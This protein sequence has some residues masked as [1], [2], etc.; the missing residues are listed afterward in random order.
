MLILKIVLHTIQELILLGLEITK[1]NP[2]AITVTFHTV[3]KILYI[4]QRITLRINFFF[5]LSSKDLIFRNNST[6][7]NMRRFA[8]FTFLP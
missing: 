6:L 5:F 4:I 3:N 7:S 8:T 1:M 2:I